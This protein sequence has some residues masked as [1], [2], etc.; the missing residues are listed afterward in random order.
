ML[1]VEGISKKQIWWEITLLIYYS[2]D[3]LDKT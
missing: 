3:S 1:C 2:T